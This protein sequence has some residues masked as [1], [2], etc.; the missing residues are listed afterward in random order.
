MYRMLLSVAKTL[1]S[2]SAL[3]L[4]FGYGLNVEL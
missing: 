4:N 3:K 1:I 2:A